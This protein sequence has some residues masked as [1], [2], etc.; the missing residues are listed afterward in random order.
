MVRTG[1]SGRKLH[2]TSRSCR[3]AVRTG[4]TKAN[5]I[6][7]F[8]LDGNPV[9]PVML[10]QM[11]ARVVVFIGAGYVDAARDSQV[12]TRHLAM[13]VRSYCDGGRGRGPRGRSIEGLI[14]GRRT[15]RLAGH[16]IE[17]SAS[18][19]VRKKRHR[20]GTA[21][22]RTITGVATH[23]YFR[24]ASTGPFASNSSCCRAARPP[25]PR[26][27]DQNLIERVRVVKADLYLC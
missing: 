2:G 5:G 15:F 16:K 20:F 9:L 8:S 17:A 23:A 14:S 26:L 19:S 10:W 1:V 3:R 12:S 24:V 22:S 21:G 11:H 7:I 6:A 27:R 4:V 18:I 13:I 25:Q